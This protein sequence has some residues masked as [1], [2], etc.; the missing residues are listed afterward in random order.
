M[1]KAVPL[2]IG[3]AALCFVQTPGEGKS[4]MTINMKPHKK[5]I[6]CLGTPIISVAPFILQ[7]LPICLSA[8]I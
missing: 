3:V 7:H 1:K 2:L 6:G 5:K 8:Q 4:H